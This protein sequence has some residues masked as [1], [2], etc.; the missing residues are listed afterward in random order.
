[1]VTGHNNFV[2]PIWVYT[3]TAGYCYH[4]GFDKNNPRAKPNLKH[5]KTADKFSV[6]FY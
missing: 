3:H 2:Y 4:F 6:V 5:L 1:M